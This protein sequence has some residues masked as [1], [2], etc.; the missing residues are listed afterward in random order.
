MLFSMTNFS[1]YRNTGRAALMAITALIMLCS[2]PAHA[3]EIKAVRFGEHPGSVRM[4]VEMDSQPAYRVA[5]PDGTQDLNL[6]LPAFTIQ[7]G[8]L[9]PAPRLGVQS[10]AQKEGAL[11]IR[12]SYPAMVKS[13]FMLPPR[14]GQSYRLVVDFAKTSGAQATAAPTLAPPPQNVMTL[15]RPSSTETSPSSS[16][17]NLPMPDRKPVAI[18]SQMD[19]PVQQLGTL[20]PPPAA[21]PRK[22]SGKPV[23]VIDAGHGGIDPGATGVNGLAEKNVTLAMAKTLRDQLK[24]T[25]DFEV[26]MTRD[27]DTYLRLG[28]RVNIA[29]QAKADLFISLHADSTDKPDIHGV[30]VY[31]LSEKSSDEQTEK[32]A[33]RENRA[34]LIAGVDLSAEDETVVNI[35]VDLT[36]RDTMNQSKFLANTLVSTLSSK[37]VRVLENPHR[38][39]GFAVLKAPD[40]PSVLI[41]MGFMS[42]RKDAHMIHTDGFRTRFSAA[43]ARSISAYFDKIDENDGT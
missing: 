6:E 28:Q 38:S 2:T 9:T 14:D 20:T 35:L 7:P 29:R 11:N 12:L 8:A 32:L 43:L 18:P 19:P 1:I 5:L 10:I 26:I 25:G 39:A 36:M 33:A 13:S 23:I 3:L 30:S 16:A 21:S 40:V 37:N 15:S 24:A 41:E 22:R 42:N 31:T 17:Q 4:V 34:D 27:T